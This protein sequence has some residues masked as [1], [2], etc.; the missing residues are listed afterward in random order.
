MHYVCGFSLRVN[1]NAAAEMS[2]QINHNM[3]LTRLQQA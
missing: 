2:T 1:Q 3:L